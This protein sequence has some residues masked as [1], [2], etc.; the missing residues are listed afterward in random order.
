MKK[1]SCGEESVMQ[2][3]NVK[4]ID[5]DDGDSNDGDDCYEGVANDDDSNN[6]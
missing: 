3:R 4:N 2:K 6:T 1:V 5:D